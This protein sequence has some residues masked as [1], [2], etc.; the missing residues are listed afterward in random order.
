MALEGTLKD[1]SLPDILQL[2]ALQRKTGVLVIRSNEDAVTMH[3]DDG[4]LVYVHSSLAAPETRLGYIMVRTGRITQ[5]QLDEALRLQEQSLRPLGAIML[6]RGTCS[7]KELSAVLSIQQ[8]TLLF[9]LFRLEQGE[10][11]FDLRESVEYE[12]EVITPLSVDLLLM[13]AM[14][15][16]DEWSEIEK[17]V[18]SRDLIFRPMPLMR[19]AGGLEEMESSVLDVVDGQRSVREVFSRTMMSEFDCYKALYTLASRGLIEEVGQKEVDFVILNTQPSVNDFIE[20]MRGLIPSRCL[21][22]IEALPE[23]ALSNAVILVI[24]ISMQSVLWSPDDSAFDKWIEPLTEI[25][26]DATRD[27]DMQTGVFESITDDIGLAIFC[28]FESDFALV[29]ADVLTGKSGVSRFR[30]Q[31]ARMAGRLLP[32]S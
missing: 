24:S 20:K 8:R 19:Q 26:S 12:R 3:F 5:D 28:D 2:I 21:D 18:H 1:F 17:V 14:Q 30:S 23:S 6:E 31:V 10:F 11:I 22:V 13:E 7:V 15:M 32:A 4:K 9:D 27:Y 29:V 25:I 16:L